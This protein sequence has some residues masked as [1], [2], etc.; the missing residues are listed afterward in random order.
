MSFVN[1]FLKCS[2]IISLKILNCHKIV[3]KSFLIGSSGFYD[4]WLVYISGQSLFE[5]SPFWI[6]PVVLFPVVWQ[7]V[8]SKKCE[9]NAPKRTPHGY[10]IYESFISNFSVEHFVMKLEIY[11]KRVQLGR[12]LILLVCSNIRNIL[13]HIIYF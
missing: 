4:D 13:Y 10:Q 9:Q 5:I 8:N 3:P 2:P 11:S 6:F 7:K 1:N 12:I